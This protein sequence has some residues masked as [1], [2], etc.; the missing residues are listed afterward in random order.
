M[1]FADLPYGVMKDQKWDVQMTER[2]I[3]AMIKQFDASNSGDCYIIGFWCHWN[4]A[5]MIEKLLNQCGFTYI[6]P[7]TWY[8]D[9]QNTVGTN[10][11]FTFAT[12]FMITARKNRPGAK[13][14]INLSDNPLERHNIIIGPTM[15]NYLLD[16]QGRRINPCQKPTYLFKQMLEWFCR[17]GDA[18]VIVCAGAGGE[19]V[20]G[21]EFGVH[22]HA[23]ETDEVQLKALSGSL[24][25]LTYSIKMLENL[26]QL[27]KKI[28]VPETTEDDVKEDET[29]DAEDADHCHVCGITD[30]KKELDHTCPKCD[31]SIH[32]ECGR[33]DGN[34]NEGV[35]LDD[36]CVDAWVQSK[37]SKT[38]EK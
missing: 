30:S 34:S 13:P 4:Q 38:S 8:K 33:P 37:K 5:G 27:P 3:E 9:N 28:A 35:C 32:R 6:T 14:H 26:T 11:A 36:K 22:V 18:V 23:F 29:K 25:T 19:V 17:P 7:I 16:D 21:L 10:T 20:A 15:R 1:L 24:Q 2:E 31:K 12:E